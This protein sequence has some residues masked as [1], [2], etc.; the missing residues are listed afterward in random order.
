M[1]LPGDR[2]LIR[3]KRLFV[4]GRQV[5]G[6]WEHHVLG[7]D[8]GPEP[9]PWPPARDA[10]PAELLPPGAPRSLFWPHADPGASHGLVFGFRDDL[11]PVIVPPGHLMAMGDNRDNSLD[12]RYWGFVPDSNVVGKAFFIWMNFGNLGRIGRF[13]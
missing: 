1:A 10:G 13:N 6:P 7:R 12:S 4:N 3:D 9:G 5:T 8:R 11:G 2:V